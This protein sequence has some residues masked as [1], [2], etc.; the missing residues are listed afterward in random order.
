MQNK[1]Y[2]WLKLHEHFFDRAVIK[3]LRKLPD[4]DT[5]VLI[6]LE[7][8][9]ISLS[10]EGFVY[11]DGL[12]QSIE[13]DIALML[14]E[15]LMT[16]KLALSALESAKLITR[17]GD[18]ADYYMQEFPDMVGSEADS[19]RRSRALRERKKQ[20]SVALQHKCNADATPRNVLATNCNTEKEIE[21]DKETEKESDIESED[22]ASPKT[23]GVYQNVFL[24]DPELQSLKERFPDSY[25]GKIDNLSA[26]LKST[27]KRYKNHYLTICRWDDRDRKESKKD[28]GNGFPNYSRAKKEGRSY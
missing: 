24:T 12:Y 3:Y 11:T 17:G 21:K 1:R 27:G 22:T 13:E 9:C 7:L 28:E 16:V 20:G 19:T 5:I 18:E 15:E 6:Y 26:Y 8:L 2:Y 4:G 23:C 25:K 10:S 14:G